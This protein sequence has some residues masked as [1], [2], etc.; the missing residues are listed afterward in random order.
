MSRKS[1]KKLSVTLRLRYED[2]PKIEKAIGDLRQMAAMLPDLAPGKK[3]QVYLADYGP[4]SVEVSAVIEVTSSV[5]DKAARQQFLL[6]I[7]RVLQDNSVQ[8]APTLEVQ[9]LQ[10]P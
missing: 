8:F 10:R 9:G 7:S 2:L 6:G 4:T 1:A 5:N 3:P